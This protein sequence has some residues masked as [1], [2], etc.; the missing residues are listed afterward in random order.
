M[1]GEAVRFFRD[2]PACIHQD[3]ERLGLLDQQPRARREAGF[4]P[5]R[6]PGA[7]PA[8]GPRSVGLEAALD[9]HIPGKKRAEEEE[10]AVGDRAGE[11]PLLEAGR[12]RSRAS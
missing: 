12:R 3:I 6:R 10:Q 8:S 5:I 2:G 1:A 9:L 11:V 7:L 4:P